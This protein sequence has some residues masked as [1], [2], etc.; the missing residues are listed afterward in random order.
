L[1][2]GK[3]LLRRPVEG[4]RG[5]ALVHALPIG[6]WATFP[7]LYRSGDLMMLLPILVLDQ[8]H[9]ILGMQLQLL[10]FDFF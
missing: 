2:S 7:S 1:R 3:T 10:Q 6:R 9:L 5:T 4:G 8:F